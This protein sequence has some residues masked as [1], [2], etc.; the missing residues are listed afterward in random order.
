M[1]FFFLSQMLWKWIR[2]CCRCS[3]YRHRNRH[4][5]RQFHRCIHDVF[6]TIKPCRP[7]GTLWPSD[8]IGRKISM[9]TSA[10]VMTCCLTAPSHYLNQY[11]LIISEVLWHS[12]EVETHGSGFLDHVFQPEYNFTRNALDISTLDMNLKIT[13]HY[14]IS[15]GP[16]SYFYHFVV[17]KSSHKL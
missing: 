12:F 8:D 7:D 15:L 3:R 5:H 2:C 4:Y 11:W 9:S 17:P 14:R 13:T 6:F 10:P 16:L 1:L